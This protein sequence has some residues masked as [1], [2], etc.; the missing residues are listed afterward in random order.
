MPR[1]HTSSRRPSGVSRVPNTCRGLS[2]IRSSWWI[3][4]TAGM[5]G[6]CAQLWRRKRLSAM[7]ANPSP[8][9]RRGELYPP[10]EPYQHGRLVVDELHTLYW[11]QCGNAA[12]VPVLFL[13][14]GPGAGC[15]AEHRRFF[16][17]NRYRIVLF[18][19]RGSGRSTPFGEVTNN[20]PAHLVADIESLR[21]ELAIDAWHVFGG[22]WGST[23]ALA[24][25]QEHPSVCLSLTLRGIFLLRASEVEWFL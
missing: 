25:A 16:D 4:S 23:L 17:P 19:Q 20:T 22:S 3:F 5:R 1:T 8:P 24:Y 11:E 6:G 18:D 15:S 12:G 14:G 21:A 10:I 9:E 2:G 13:H 7:S